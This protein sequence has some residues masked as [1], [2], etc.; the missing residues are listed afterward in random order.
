MVTIF[1]DSEPDPG[2]HRLGLGL[3]LN[4]P[5]L[6]FQIIITR[7]WLVK[8]LMVQVVWKKRS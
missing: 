1:Y 6:E 4:K 8:N 7:V 5:D 3:E 2:H